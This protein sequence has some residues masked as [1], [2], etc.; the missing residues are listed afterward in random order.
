MEGGGLRSPARHSRITTMNKQELAQ[1]Y[2]KKLGNLFE[3]LL[4]AEKESTLEERPTVYAHSDTRIARLI[5][6]YFTKLHE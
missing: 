5:N 4:Q 1:E 6:N 3:E 2:L